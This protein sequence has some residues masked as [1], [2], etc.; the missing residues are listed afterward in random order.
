[1]VSGG[2]NRASR[3]VVPVDYEEMKSGF[4][5]GKAAA[6]ADW[7]FRKEQREFAVLVN[8]LRALKWAKENPVRATA[9]TRVY[10]AKPGV[11]QHMNAMQNK[12]RRAAWRAVERAVTC[13]GCGVAFCPLPK[14]GIA[15][16]FCTDRCK[17]ASHSRLRY[18]RAKGAA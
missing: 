6:L 9:R 3:P 1:M 16:A 14:K 7:S 13:R 11:R 2:S 10:Q 12:R 18:A 4:Q 8:R 17:N 15:R 5:S